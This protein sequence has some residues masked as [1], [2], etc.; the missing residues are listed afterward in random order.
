M[1][2][3]AYCL[4][5]VHRAEST[6]HASRLGAIVDALAA[7]G[8]DMPVIFPLHPRTRQILHN[9][10]ALDR[11][12][13]A[14]ILVDPLGYLD[15]VQLEKHAALIAT[16]SGGVQK[17]AFFHQVPCVTLR[18]E[19]EWTELVDA[20]WNRLAPPTDIGTILSA[21]RAAPGSRGQPIAPY[22][23]G[24]AAGLIVGCLEQALA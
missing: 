14:V 21:L 18:D 11:L 20:D 16:D 10:G 19:T 5:T 3:G 24:N 2:A 7:F 15:M 23:D 17:E 9:L 8:R 6:D 22:G 13:A 1:R 4:A 12:A